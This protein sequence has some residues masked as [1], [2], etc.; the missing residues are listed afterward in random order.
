M[1]LT[2]SNLEIENSQVQ[3]FFFVCLLVCLFLYVA[4]IDIKGGTMFWK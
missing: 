4:E 1:Y 3:T 2:R